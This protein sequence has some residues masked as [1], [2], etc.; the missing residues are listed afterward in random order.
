MNALLSIE[1]ELLEPALVASAEHLLEL[2]PTQIRWVSVR[3]TA[4]EGE[5][6][7]VAFEAQADDSRLAV[8]NL[9][10]LARQSQPHGTVVL[11]WYQG[12]SESFLI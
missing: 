2:H 6:S 3:L 7:S 8:R 5:E 12:R 10:A 1:L 9:V 4:D 11:V